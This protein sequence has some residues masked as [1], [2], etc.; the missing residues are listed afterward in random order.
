MD[1]THLHLT[2]V[3]VPIFGIFFGMIFLF[4]G[5]LSKNEMFKK[6][7]LVTFIFTALVAIPTFLTG[8]PSKEVVK[9]IPGISENIINEHE[10]LAEKAIWFIE[11]LGVLSLFVF[12]LIL[13]G[14][15]N[16]KMMVLITLIVSMITLG[17]MAV[18]G[19]SGGK[20][21]HSEIVDSATTSNNI[22][23]E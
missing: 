7:G 2:L 5:I 11:V 23:N 15:K 12:Y 14:K 3:H 21:R 22:V 16:L 1:Y 19:N 4:Y 10:E 9:N 18:V 8:D 17:M 6:A 20:I 13:K